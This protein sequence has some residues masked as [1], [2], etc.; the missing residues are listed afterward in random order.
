MKFLYRIQQLKLMRIRIRNPG[1][2]NRRSRALSESKIVFKYPS[3]HTLK[4]RRRAHNTCAS[5]W[6]GD[7]S[8]GVSPVPAVS[9]NPSDPSPQTILK[10]ELE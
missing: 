8:A 3:Q 7:A 10:T 6:I 9:Q 1:L 5:F 4:K 2:K